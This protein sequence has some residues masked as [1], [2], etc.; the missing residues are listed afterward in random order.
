MSRTVSIDPVTR[1]EGAGRIEVTLDASGRVERARFRVVDFKGFET[2]CRGRAA[3]EMPTLTQK[4]CGV[5]PT[6]HH[7]ASVKALDRV[8]RAA[9]PAAANAVRELAYQ[10]FLFEDHLL[11]FL[12]MGGPDFLASGG[13][14]RSLPALLN[15]PHGSVLRQLLEVRAR[16]R[17]LATLS[18]G[19]ALYPVFGVPGGVSRTVRE[20]DRERIQEIAKEAVSA[21]RTALELFHEHIL[22]SPLYSELLE[23]PH[24]SHRLYSMG[25]V[26]RVGTLS[27]YDGEVRVVGP[28]GEQFDQFDAGAFETRLEERVEPW[29]YMKP[30][31][32]KE[33]GWQGY[34]DGSA[35]GIYRVGPL[36]R[37]NVADGL[38]TPL[39]QAESERMFDRLGEK[40]AHQTMA[41]HWARL[42]ES[43]YAAERMQELAAEERLTRQD[44]RTPIEPGGGE[45]TGVCEAPRGTLFHRYLVDGDGIVES[46]NLVV[47]TQHNGAAINM[48]VEA[49]ARALIREGVIP[50]HIENRVEMAFRA[51]DP[52]LA[53]AAHR[54]ETSGR[55]PSRFRVL[56]HQGETVYSR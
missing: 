52:C 4:I 21:A 46:A 51:Y 32:L 6:A 8:F 24:L 43:L 28:E 26:D 10:G 15:G 36:A 33:I 22:P 25:L 23:A 29:T 12:V 47:A 48:S 55:P 41:Y 30:V 40:P 5:C 20:E 11:H 3:E 19:S 14:D 7:I 2:F 45:G 1:L 56:D 31:F 50:Q 16:V 35:S 42:I 27:P 9:P 13:E 18:S 53:C 17:D 34:T 44:V 37:L 49:V 39:A 38:P 54:I